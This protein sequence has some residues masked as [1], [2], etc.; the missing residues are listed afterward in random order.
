MMESGGPCSMVESPSSVQKCAARLFDVEQIRRV[1]KQDE[2][3]HQEV[4]VRKP[5]GRCARQ[6]E[7]RS[8]IKEMRGGQR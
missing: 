2:W 3:D 4:I 1:Q 8:F 5:T 7:Q 6:E